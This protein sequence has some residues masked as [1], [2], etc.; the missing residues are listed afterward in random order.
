MAFDIGKNISGLKDQVSQ[1][2]GVAPGA[3]GVV[4]GEPLPYKSL[5]ILDR[6]VQGQLDATRWNQLYRYSFQICKANKDGSVFLTGSTEIPDGFNAAKVS[7]RLPPQSIT[8][9][10]PFASSVVA[11]NKGILEENNGIVFRNITIAGTT[12][13]YPDA[14]VVNNSSNL[15]GPLGLVQSIFPGVTTAIGDVLKQV[16]A[17]KNAVVGDDSKREL[18]PNP[19]SQFELQNTGY[20]QFWVLHN[21]LVAYAEMKKR[22]LSGTDASEFRLIFNSPKDNIA[23]VIT[24]VSF[25]L[26]KDKSE[27]MLYRYSISF[28]AW[29]IAIG[30]ASDRGVDVLEGVPTPDNV[31]AIKAITEILRETRKTI[32]AVSNVFEGVYSDIN[33]IF[34]VYNQGMLV[35]KDA[36]GVAE[37]IADFPDQIKQS[38]AILLSGPQNDFVASLKSFQASSD[39]RSG[40]LNFS[41]VDEIESP[42]AGIGQQSSITAAGGS[43]T[44]T[45][46]APGGESTPAPSSAFM[47]QAVG[48]FQQ[49][50]DDP[51]FAAQTLDNFDIPEAVQADLDNARDDALSDTTSSDIREM[52]DGLKQVSDNFGEAIGAGNAEY[53]AA[54]NLPSPIEVD[55]S[56]VEDDIIN[57]SALVEAQLNWL[58]LLGTGQIFQERESDPFVFANT[59]LDQNDQVASP[60]SATPVVFERGRSLENLAQHYLG[61]ANRAREIAIL[62][63]LRPP[64]IDEVGFTRNIFGANGRQF[65]VNG[66]DNLAINQ[67]IVIKGSTV[68]QTRRRIINIEDIG[69]NQFRI[70]VDGSENLSIYGAGTSPFLFARIPGTVG[71]GD[72]VLIP[73]SAQPDDPLSTRP[74]SI[75]DKLAHAEKVFKIDIALDDKG[76]DLV[77]APSGDVKRSYGYD[78]ALQALRIAVET[79]RG[80]LEQHKAFGLGVPIGGRTSDLTIADIKEAVSTTIL[81]DPRFA[82]AITEVEINGSVSKIKINAH[83][84]AGTGQVPVEF[85]VGKA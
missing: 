70:T 23:Y 44:Q 17:V 43:P 56:P 81:S 74:N 82:D 46:T 24:P 67:V 6:K 48:V 2:L 69:N 39:T 65:V 41:S 3:S 85:E 50:V 62:N 8:I 72:I 42:H 83:G 79:E 73:S 9:T 68:A 53:N 34:N 20:Y 27:P 61:D 58:A 51:D 64:F 5:G 45:N 57:Q 21:F 71:A 59:H 80:E 32:Q 12:G 77:V 84:A 15:K 25:D 63:S 35:L 28:R 30:S 76:R 13:L 37:E 52:V 36:S 14:K 54:Y 60:L 66:D 19:E 7:L 22:K 47:T 31:G 55:R 4:D 78:N 29:D 38:A 75:F 16:K 11:T 10:T 1:L 40:T 33:S 18:T 49:A 26:R